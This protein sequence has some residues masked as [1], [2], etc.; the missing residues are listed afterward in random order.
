MDQKIEFTLIPNAY[1]YALTNVGHVYNTNTKRRLKRQWIGNSWRTM[2]R[3]SDGSS[4][5]FRHDDINSANRKELSES[6]LDRENTRPIPNWPRYEITPYGTIW[7]VRTGA[8]GRGSGAPFIV[9]EFFHRDKRHVN[10]SNK[11]GVRRRQ[12][13]KRLVDLTWGTDGE[14]KEN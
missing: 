13:V 2:I 8:R 11:F 7:C 1:P 6:V 5:Y 14:F 12:S 3:S 4:F 9:S 10:L